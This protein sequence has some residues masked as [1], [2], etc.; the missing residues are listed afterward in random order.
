MTASFLGITA[1]C[2]SQADRKRHI[3][4]LAVMHFPSPHTA[5]RIT[6]M[7]NGELQEWNNGSNIV[8]SFKATDSNEDLDHSEDEDDIQCQPTEVSESSENIENHPDYSTSDDDISDIDTTVLMEEN[9]ADFEAAEEVHHTTLSSTHFRRL[10][11]F[12]HTLQLYSCK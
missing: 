5:A 8:A 1:Q 7:L 4:T 3:V 10:G 11:C 2:F 6:V 9:I 12:V